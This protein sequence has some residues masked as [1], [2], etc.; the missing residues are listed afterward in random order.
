MLLAVGR[1]DI[2][3]F[4]HRDGV[5]AKLLDILL[6]ERVALGKLLICQRAL[7]CQMRQLIDPLDL[8]LLH[9]FT[10][11]FSLFTLIFDGPQLVKR[12]LEGGDEIQ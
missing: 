11:H 1:H 2:G 9:N 5:A 12:Q 8:F 3:V 4:Q 7:L 6:P 10:F